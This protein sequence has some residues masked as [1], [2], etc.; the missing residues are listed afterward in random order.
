MKDEYDGK[1]ICEIT[2]LKS[3]MY[4]IRDV[5]I[6]KKAYLKDII[7]LLVIMDIM[8]HFLIKKTLDIK[9]VE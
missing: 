7:H 6:M 9:S 5:K 4:S 1:I 8:I 3:K 2:T